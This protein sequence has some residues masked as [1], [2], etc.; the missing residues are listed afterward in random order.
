MIAGLF[1][2]LVIRQHSPAQAHPVVVDTKR[3]MSFSSESDGV[4][5]TEQLVPTSFTKSQGILV[6]A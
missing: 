6:S 3:N 2:E 4:S 5:P 1:A